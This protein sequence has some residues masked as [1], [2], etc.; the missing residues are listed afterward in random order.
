MPAAVG[1][2]SVF[3]VFHG[4]SEFRLNL[5]QRWCT[6]VRGGRVMGLVRQVLSGDN[7]A[8]TNSNRNDLRVEPAIV[9]IET[10]VPRAGFVA[11]R[12]QGAVELATKLDF[13]LFQ[14]HSRAYARE[15]PCERFAR[16]AVDV[17]QEK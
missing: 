17:G 12:W 15:R 13:N 4:P 6:P 14:R 1:F 10:V 2:S 3:Q 8:F 7:T 9:W 11:V 5:N 16:V